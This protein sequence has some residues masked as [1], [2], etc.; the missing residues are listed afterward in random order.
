MSNST[1]STEQSTVQQSN[2]GTSTFRS[3]PSNNWSSSDILAEPSVYRAYWYNLGLRP[4]ADPKLVKIQPCKEKKAITAVTSFIRRNNYYVIPTHGK[5]YYIK[6]Q[7]IK[8]SGDH[9]FSIEGNMLP[10]VKEGLVII[11]SN[12]YFVTIEDLVRRVIRKSRKLNLKKTAF[13]YDDFISGN[14]FQQPKSSAINKS[15][16][17][18]LEVE[19]LS[20][21]SSEATGTGIDTIKS[22]LSGDNFLAELK[23]IDLAISQQVESLYDFV[24]SEEE[25]GE[26]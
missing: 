9:L 20:G 25:W 13:T 18:D 8:P 23:E 17:T 4:A 15:T 24:Y 16:E 1:S 21:S 5:F 22:K 26:T 14:A 6:L 10:I 7:D 3:F 19:S 2:S 12:V 11:E